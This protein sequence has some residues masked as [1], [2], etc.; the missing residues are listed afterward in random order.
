MAKGIK[1]GFAELRGRYKK[2]HTQHKGHILYTHSKIYK[3]KPEK[4]SVKGDAAI[5]PEHK[6]VS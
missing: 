6:T 2:G 1:I 5:L 3:K 4:T